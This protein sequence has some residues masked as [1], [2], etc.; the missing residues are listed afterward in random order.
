MASLRA[1]LA[2]LLAADG[3]GA[4]SLALEG[5]RAVGYA[6]LCF[7]FSIEYRGRDAFVDELY[8]APAARGKGVG[9]ALLRALEAEARAASVRT[10]H[11]EVE[12]R[13]AGARTLYVDE[14]FRPTGR[15]LLSK[16]LV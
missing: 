11:L 10:L 2:E 7:G 1:T 13:N 15:E 8:V 16:R 9:R 6:A 3:A 5:E 4:V 14:G 12:Q